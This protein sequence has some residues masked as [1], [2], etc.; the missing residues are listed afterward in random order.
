MKKVLIALFI[1]V[2][3][4]SQELPKITKTGF[5]PVITE[6]TGKNAADLFSKTKEWVLKYY[7]NPKEVLK[8]EIENNHIRIEGYCTNGYQTKALGITNYFDYTYSIEIDFKDGKYKYSFFVHRFISKGAYCYYSYLDFFK[9]DGS[10]RKAYQL[11]YDT[12]N[13]SANDIYLSHYDYLTGKTDLK[14]NDW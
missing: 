3:G 1:S 8:A 11:A 2:L 13:K 4:F 6:V 14:K 7:K 12:L 5:E 10:V 9:E